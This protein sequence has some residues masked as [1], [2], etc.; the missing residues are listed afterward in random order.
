MFAHACLVL[1]KRV[2]D[3]EWDCDG[4]PEQCAHAFV[5]SSYLR[6]H[7]YIQTHTNLC[8][9]IQTEYIPVIKLTHIG[10]SIPVWQWT[11]PFPRPSF[12]NGA[13]PVVEWDG[14]VGIRGMGG[15][16]CGTSDPGTQTR[17]VV[18]LEHELIVCAAVH[19]I[20]SEAEL[21]SGGQSSVAG[22]A[23]EAHEVEHLVTGPHH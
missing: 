4:A 5:E 21:L 10:T 6:T 22:G 23:R 9:D 14:S 3:A 8:I 20:V 19:L 12:L 11:L 18:S 1:K 7:I 13:H 15:K 17:D 2:E 16:P